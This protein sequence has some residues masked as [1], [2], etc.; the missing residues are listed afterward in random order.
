MKLWVRDTLE[1]AVATAAETIG[2]LIVADQ[3]TNAFAVD[4]KAIAGVAGLSAFASVLKS[5]AALKVNDTV[6]PASLVR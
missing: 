3:I 1:R 2:A 4:W 5:L 6:S